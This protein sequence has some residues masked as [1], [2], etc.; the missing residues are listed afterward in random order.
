[1]DQHDRPPGA[2][3]D[4]VAAAGHMSEALET[5]E[6]ARGHLYSFHQLIGEADFALDEVLAKLRAAGAE[7]LAAELERE[8]V[9]RNVLEGRWTFQVV[10]EF[11]DGYWSVFRDYERRVRDAMTS[12]NRHVYEA[13]L[14]ARRRA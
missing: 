13:E 11:D 12:G 9:G 4:A 2:S 6:R 3:D 14:K 8:L 1:M 5:L 7:D 10:E